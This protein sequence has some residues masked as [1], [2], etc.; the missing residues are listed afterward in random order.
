MLII[1]LE[2]L[3]DF[4]RVGGWKLFN[5]TKATL[6]NYICLL[7]VLELRPQ[8][9][10]TMKSFYYSGHWCIHGYLTMVC[11]APASQVGKACAPLY[12]TIY[13]CE[14]TA[15]GYLKS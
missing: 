2:K 6:L 3:A 9:S 4:W 7:E 8:P 5:A 11:T 10:T 15:G 13:S 1:I 12:F 14:M